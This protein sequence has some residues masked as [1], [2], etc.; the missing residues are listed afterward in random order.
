MGGSKS[1]FS[2]L[3]KDFRTIV[4][5][6]DNSTVNVMGKGDVNIRTKK[7][8]IETISNV[9]YIPDLKNNL[10]SVGQL[11]EKGYVTTIKGGAC[12]IYDPKRGLIAHVKMT[13]NR[14]F[15]R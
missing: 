9:F 6:G 15:P 12:E 7:D 11:Q 3:N 1:F 8:N 13:Q 10:L 4:S 2:N 5:F 14:L